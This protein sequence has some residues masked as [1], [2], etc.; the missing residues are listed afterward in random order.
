MSRPNYI[1]VPF[2]AEGSEGFY[3]FRGIA[4]FS[5]AGIVIEYESKLLGLY[6]NEVKEVRL[7]LSD[8][9]DIRFKKG[10]FKFF[11]SIHIRLD[12]VTKFGGLPNK[13]GRFKMKVKREDWD[14]G[15][16]A[17]R[18]I[19]SHLM[20]EDFPPDAI[21]GSPVERLIEGDKSKY[22]T[23]DLNQTRKLDD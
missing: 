5:S 10:L 23:N 15:D 14:L 20:P 2:K 21:E 7:K 18:Y 3:E 6:G 9:I 16:S 17:V 22:E 13:G 11:S 12:S 8:I 19:K 1:A 4:K